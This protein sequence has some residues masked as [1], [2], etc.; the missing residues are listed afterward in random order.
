MSK[1]VFTILLI[2][3]V[4]ALN[5]QFIYFEVGDTFTIASKSGANLREG[6]FIESKK[7]ITIPFGKRVVST[8][9]FQGYDTIDDREGGW[10][11]VIYNGKEGFIFSGLITALNVPQF[12]STNLDCSY[13]K[14]FEKVI[15]NNV[16]T[17]LCSGQNEYKGFDGDGKD[18]TFSKWE[19][20]SNETEIFYF[21]GYESLDLIVE[22]RAINMNDILNL[23]DFYLENLKTKCPELYGFKD[24][25]TGEIKLTKAGGR[26]I[27]IE[28]SGVLFYAEQSLN[29]IIISLN[30]FNN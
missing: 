8:S 22:S 10:V 15:R 24:G 2:L 11:K 20:Y 18:H 12:D 13:F 7:I 25:S 21:S 14:W 29:K 27:K 4:G 23:L 26:I 3:G 1:L 9:L 30:L 5:A 28:N 16:D 17:L 6:N 19:M